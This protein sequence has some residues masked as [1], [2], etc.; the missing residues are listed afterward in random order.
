MS[1]PTKRQFKFSP[2]RR[3]DV[4][5]NIGLV[6][7]SGCGKTLSALRLAK[8]I[9][10]VRGGK[11]VGVDTEANRMLHYADDPKWNI[12]FYHCPFSEPF[13]SLD[14]RDVITQAAAAAEGGVVVVDSMSHEH[15]GMGGY[16]MF[17]NEEAERMGKGENKSSEAVSWRAYAKPAAHR[18]MLI[19]KIVQ[20][21]CA[22]IFCFRAKERSIMRKN[23][24]KQEVVTIGWQAIAGEAFVF[25]QTLRCLLPP[26][27]NGLPDW[28]DEAFAHGV[29]KLPG[30]LA[31]I[32]R[33]NL[34]AI[35]EEHGKQ[36]ALWAKG[37]GL[38]TKENRVKTAPKDMPATPDQKHVSSAFAEAAFK[39]AEW[40]TKA[41]QAGKSEIFTALIASVCKK[42]PSELK[43]LEEINIAN[44]ACAEMEKE[45]S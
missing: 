30:S 35:D 31:Q 27:A 15:E 38:T 42:K 37:E 11:I 24:G 23:G 26:G 21:N 28:S 18:S 3:A 6:G 40:Q 4:P 44:K 36:L 20:T 32:F 17:H 29:P 1:E 9:Q 5:L 33:T 22:F 19:N 13:G 10:S 7:P 8:G 41:K 39:L 14:Y 34:R 45:L 16:L 12:Q 43:S 25:E 2:A